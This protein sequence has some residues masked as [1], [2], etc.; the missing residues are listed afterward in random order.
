MRVEEWIS[1][2]GLDGVLI[3]VVTF[4]LTGLVKLPLK[5]LAKKAKTPEKYTRYIT[6]LP[7]LIAFGLTVL[8]ESILRKGFVFDE[9]TVRLWLTSGN[10]S[11]AIYAVAEKF[12]PAERH[13]LSTEEAEQNKRMMERLVEFLSQSASAAEKAEAEGSDSATEEQ[14]EIVREKIVLRKKKDVSVSEEQ[15]VCQNDKG[16]QEGISIK[17]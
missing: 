9:E 13:F 11:L 8:Y 12:L 16:L 10:L 4:V 7:I 1:E 5:R 14:S 17:S 15:K 3:G 6:F 2:Y